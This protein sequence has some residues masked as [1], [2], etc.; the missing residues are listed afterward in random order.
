[1]GIESLLC[2][3]EACEDSGLTRGDIHDI[4]LNNALRTL[5][6]HLPKGTSENYF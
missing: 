5:V 2:L 6:P 1:M 3:R 4:F